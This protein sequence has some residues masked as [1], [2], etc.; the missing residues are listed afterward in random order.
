M[1]DRLFPHSYNR[2]F[3]DEI[4]HNIIWQSANV[5]WRVQVGRGGITK[6]NGM[7]KMLVIGE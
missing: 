3:S 6:E 5:I 7:L 2:I 1:T 4:L